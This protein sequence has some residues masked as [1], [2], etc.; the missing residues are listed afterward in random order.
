MVLPIYNAHSFLSKRT[1]TTP[2]PNGR[3]IFLWPFGICIL[4]NGRGPAN[5]LYIQKKK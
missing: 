1:T 4:K 2:G 5:M 3:D